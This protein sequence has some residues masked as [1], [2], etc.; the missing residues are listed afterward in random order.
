M[1]KPLFP[2]FPEGEEVPVSS[3]LSNEIVSQCPRFQREGAEFRASATTHFRGDSQMFFVGCDQIAE[4]P[5]RYCRKLGCMPCPI[6]YQRGTFRSRLVQVI[7]D[8][9]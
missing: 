6:K 9:N 7:V 2:A 8:E 5:N 1:G 3:L 4:E